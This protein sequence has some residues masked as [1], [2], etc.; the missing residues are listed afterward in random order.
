MY[1]YKIYF[2]DRELKIEYHTITYQKDISS[3]CKYLNIFIVRWNLE[4]LCVQ[5]LDNRN[6]FVCN[7]ELLPTE[8][9]MQRF[10]TSLPERLVAYNDF[11]NGGI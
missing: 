11:V 8:L 2:Y 9:S 1:K 7:V 5:L 3:L 4:V 6:G 10:I